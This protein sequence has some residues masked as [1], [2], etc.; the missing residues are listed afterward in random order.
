MSVGLGVD[1]IVDGVGGRSNL[2]LVR[3]NKRSNGYFW[4][5]EWHLFCVCE[6]VRLILKVSVTPDA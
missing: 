2:A 4:F 3:S 5:L 6:S 1:G